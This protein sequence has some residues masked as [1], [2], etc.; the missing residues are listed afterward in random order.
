MAE[1]TSE[2]IKELGHKIVNIIN[3]FKS[4]SEKTHDALVRRRD[5]ANKSIQNLEEENNKLRTTTRGQ[6]RQRFTAQEKETLQNNT[7]ALKVLN[8]KLNERMLEYKAQFG[9]K[10]FKH[11]ERK[12]TD[13]VYAAESE[14]K[15]KGDQSRMEK[16]KAGFYKRSLGFLSSISK[17]IKS[18]VLA[19]LKFVKSIAEKGIKGILT[20]LGLIAFLKFLEGIE[21]ATK[22]FGDNPSFGE[23]LASG[24]AN[25]LLGLQ[26]YLA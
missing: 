15:T 3:I 22:W 25:F 7:E 5:S 14:G 2:D 17:G 12:K 8:E 18:I 9:E 26:N 11:Q 6:Q 24:L 21:K 23:V 13:P 20:G 10:E 1:A 19:P 16:I 4:S